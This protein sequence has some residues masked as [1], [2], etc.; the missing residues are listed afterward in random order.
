MEF[1]V[2]AI[3][4]APASEIYNGWLDSDV[5]SKMTG[6]EAIVSNEINGTFSTWDEYISGVNLDLKPGYIK[7]SWRTIE[8]E[9]SQ[10]DSIVEITFEEVEPKKTV[11]TLHH[12][13]LPLQD[14][15]YKK[16]WAEHYFEPMKEYF[17]Q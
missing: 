12:K 11:I 13:N 4:E 9:V 6:A 2:S 8:F 16:G 7:Q 3:I 14:I 5:H 15:Q 10:P 1:T 17:E